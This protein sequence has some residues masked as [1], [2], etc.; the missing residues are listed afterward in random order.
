MSEGMGAVAPASSSATST[1]SSQ[2]AEIATAKDAHTKKTQPS[3]DVIPAKVSSQS[4]KYRVKVD[5]KEVEVDDEELKR[6][7]THAQAANKRFQEAAAK[8]KEAQAIF[9]AIESGDVKY[10]ESK[11]GKAKTKE[12]FESYL[13]ADLEEAELREKN[14]GE[15]R[16]RQL[17]AE[18]REL[19]AK[20]EAEKKAQQER[21]YQ[22]TLKKVHEELDQEVHQAL[23]KLGTKPTPRLAMRVIDEMIVRLEGKGEK[24]SAEAAS[25]H[26]MK[27]I[28]ADIREYLPGLPVEKL[29]E[30]IP[31]DVIDRIRQHEVEKVTGELSKK[32]V[33]APESKRTQSNQPKTI[34]DWFSLKEKK[35]NRRS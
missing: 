16:A 10:L 34:D 20:Q 7:Y 4:N 9:K 31:Q 12:I 14:P 22:E 33:R 17:E 11:L 26:A 19:K 6:G 27:G 32:R 21:E 8:E 13:I 23:S 18:N 35:L 29:L 1:P 3:T 28:Y 15:Y 30:V 5:G 25:Q 24:I 2:S